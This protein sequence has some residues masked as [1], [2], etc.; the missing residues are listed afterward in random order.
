MESLK[1]ITSDRGLLSEHLEI[2]ISAL[3][4]ITN[5]VKCLG[6]KCIGYFPKILPPAL[7]LW[8][9]TVSA[10]SYANE[11]DSEKEEDD[12]RKMLLQ[13]S[14]LMLFS[15]LVKKM[16]A[17]VTS[18][19][20][21]IFRAIFLSDYVDNSIRSGVLALVVEHIDKT[22]VLQALCNLALSDNIYAVSNTAD[23][24]LYLNAFNNA[25]ESADKKVA[26]SQS[27]LVMKWL[28]KSF[29][30][31]VEH[32]E[33][34]FSE[35]TI[36]S[37]EASFHQS[38][39][40]YV[41]KLNDKNFRPLFASLVR[42]A[43]NGEGAGVLKSNESDRLVAFFKIFNK[44]QDSL[45]SIVT[46]YYSYLLDPAIK[47]LKEFESGAKS[48][49]NLRRLLLHSLSSSFKYDQD[50]FWSHQSRFEI[51]LEPLMGQLTNIEQSLG[52]H[53]VKAIS[54]FVSNVSL[55]EHNEK[56][57]RGLIRY[58]SNEYENSLNTKIWAIRVLKSVFQKVGEQWLSFLPTFI[59]YIAELLEDDDEEVELEVRK[60]LVRV[61]EN[62]LGEPLDRYLS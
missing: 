42:W 33:G 61:I 9:S 11:D 38:A 1:I 12:D 2:N 29:E 30:F 55:E 19:L 27:S 3:N 10:E 45:K 26:T 40:K 34:H 49:T 51:V 23:L 52:K 6:V 16:P 20:R 5:I 60:D 56:L 31:R 13:G 43:F 8:E 58:I 35:N 24:G 57:V 62:I 17:F 4:A 59:P 37:I 44:L 36:A 22:Q 15:Y 7:K 41:M 50:D 53:L 46:S 21:A 39:L 28:I 32:G 14:I 54:F 48:Q 18:N 25:I 47:L